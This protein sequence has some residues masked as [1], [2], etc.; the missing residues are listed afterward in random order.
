[1]SSVS[2]ADLWSR[3]LIATIAQ[4]TRWQRLVG[5]ALVAHGDLTEQEARAVVTSDAFGVLAAELRRA[6]AG[7]HDVDTLMPYLVATRSLYDADDVA[8][9]LHHRLHHATG[10]PSMIRQSSYIAGLIPRRPRTSPR[11]RPAGARR[12]RGTDRAA[13]PHPGGAGDPS[14]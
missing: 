14:W 11:R 1:M 5:R 7:G 3:R 6:E 9:V 8:A 12:A 10:R 4:R 2:L 13:R